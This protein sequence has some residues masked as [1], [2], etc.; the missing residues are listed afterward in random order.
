MWL[1]DDRACECRSS[2]RRIEGKVVLTVDADGCPGEGDLV[3]EPGCRETAVRALE[4]RDAEVVR[5]RRSGRERR[6]DGAGARLL[7]AAG[8][9]AERLR[10]RDEE[11]A[12]TVCR[13]P[14]GAAGIATDRA[15]TISTAATETGITE[16]VARIEGYDDAFRPWVGPSFAG[17]R[18]DR[19]VPDGA[20]LR[21][22]R[23]LGTGATVT[24]YNTDD[25]GYYRIEPAEIGLCSG[26]TETLARARER[27]ASGAV[28]GGDRAPGRAVRAVA[29]DD[30][31]VGMLTA[32]LEKHTTGQGVFADLLADPAVSDAFVT[33]PASETPVRVVADDERLVT[34]VRLTPRGVERFASRLRRASGRAF[35][36]A[37][38]TLDA[39]VET[40]GRDVRAAAVS[41]PASD[42]VGVAL[43]A[44]GD[45]TWT[46][47]ALVE[48]GTL[49]ANAGALLSLAVQR[50]A[51][52]LVAG[53]RGAGKTTLLGALLWELPPAVRTVVV[54]DT[55]E[56]PVDALRTA[57]RD[58]QPLRTEIEDR[59][60][61][62]IS[63]R[64]ALTTALR[65][66]EGALVVGEVRG[67]EA[68]TLYEAMRVGASGNTVLGTIHGDGPEVVRERL[69]T[70]LGVSSSS[71]R[72]TDVVVELRPPP[73]RRVTGIYE[74]RSAA[75]GTS[76]VGLYERTG[77]RLEPTGRIDRGNSELVAGLATPGSEYDDVRT[78]LERRERLLERLAATDRI[79]P[80]AVTNAYRGR[81]SGR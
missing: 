70:D 17:A 20:R 32:V 39:T 46:L 48:N 51:A 25:G 10:F 31:P 12:E 81:G 9:L 21:E 75:D 4:E 68:V 55:P 63:P 6:Y 35:S 18:F 24:L 73:D 78:V 53:P 77:D 38:P 2:I 56:L 33:A 27:L 5:V 71:F 69:V 62:S 61:P 57:G 16:C 19:C 14:I 26:A 15:G 8:R 34:N 40:G 13:D 3:D 11:L 66:G 64:E 42:G 79:D 29:D 41:P 1:R 28:A 52:G 54:E 67:E 47:P 58:V 76:F 60:G 45:Q 65:L 36:R 30:D 7:V 44:H 72:A 59:N 37:S 74:V 43:R 80:A 23:A 49:P 50:G 22:R